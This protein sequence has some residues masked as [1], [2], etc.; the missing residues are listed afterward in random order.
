MV[1]ALIGTLTL[2]VGVADPVSAQQNETV[3][4]ETATDDTPDELIYQFESG[5]ELQSVTYDNGTAY[6]QL[7][8]PDRPTTVAI[9][10]GALE[11]SGSFNFKTIRLRS[12][13][14][15]LVTLDVRDQAVV[16]TSGDDGYY[17]EGDVGVSVVD[18]PTNELIQIGALSGV[19]G[20]II[21]LALVIGQLRRRHSNT[22]EELYSDR[23]VKIE[24]DPVEGI[25]EWLLRALKN[26]AESKLRIALVGALV[27]V[28]VG[29]AA[30]TVPTPGEIWSGL[31]DTQRLLVAGSLGASVVALGPVYLLVKR[32]WDPD[33]EFVLDL[34]SKDVYRAADGDK[35]GSVATYSAPPERIDDLEVDG[36]LTTLSTPGGRCH[37]VRG[38]DPEANE[39]EGNPPYLH[40][41]REVSIEADRIEANRQTLTDLAQIGRDLI[42][43][44][45]TFRVTADAAAVRDIDANIRHTLSAG[46][47]S[48][49][50]VLQQAVEGT[51]YE[52]TYQPDPGDKDVEEPDSPDANPTP[53]GEKT[54]SS[55]GGPA[56]DADSGGSTGGEPA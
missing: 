12:E 45:S 32:I 50:D 13:E 26:T 9:G 22:Y 5:A 44:M 37:L 52:G 31:S 29:M 27:L 25:Y 6:I 40:D 53:D 49:E 10:E 4:N 47:D 14:E 24:E 7:A 2:G 54:G 43:A 46:G 48:L 35:S 20:S 41:D 18:R 34:D 28:F 39:A 51:R 38:M 11:E 30:G 42:A 16:I 17:H 36:Q 15:R 8:S 56:V 33:R 23:R 21:A 55:E 19:V 3:T 1:I